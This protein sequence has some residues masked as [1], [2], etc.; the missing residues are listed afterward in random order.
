MF[1]QHIGLDKWLNGTL[2][3]SP[4]TSIKT[5]AESRWDSIPR[6]LNYFLDSLCLKY[7]YHPIPFI[8]TP[9]R[10]SVFIVMH[11]LVLPSVHMCF[12]VRSVF[13]TG[14]W[15]SKLLDRNVYHNYLIL[16][17]AGLTFW[18]QGQEKLFILRRCAEHK[19]GL[20][21]SKLAPPLELCIVLYCSFRVRYVCFEPVERNW[22]YL[23]E[24]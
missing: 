23:A 21:R 1:T 18:G 17:C 5:S 24:M 8:F 10:I 20:P 16:L 7:K 11:L 13:S 9:E 22:N 4:I 19:F 3:S 12:F 2:I 15:K 14:G 6:K